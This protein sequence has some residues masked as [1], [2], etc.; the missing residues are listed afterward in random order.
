MILQVAQRRGIPPAP[1]EEVLID[2][3]LSRAGIIHALRHLLPQK[4]MVPALHRR[5]S[6][7]F[8]LGKGLTADTVLVIVDN[9]AAIH[10]GAAP[11]W[12]NA[13]EPLIEV[14][15]AATAKVLAPHQKKNSGPIAKVVMPQPPNVALLLP[16]KI[17]LAVWTVHRAGVLQ[18]HQHGIAPGKSSY[19]VIPQPEYDIVHGHP[20]LP[21]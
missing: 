4:I 5:R 6:Y 9:M 8:P 21:S 11:T 12:L 16:K 1:G 20:V 17:T 19:L 3:Q 13:R 14:A 2:P 10:F 7:P 18:L 15:P